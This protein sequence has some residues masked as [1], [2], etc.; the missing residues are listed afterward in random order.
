MNKDHEEYRADLLELLE[1]WEYM[2]SHEPADWEYEEL[3][4]ELK[5]L[6]ATDRWSVRMLREYLKEE[7]E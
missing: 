1:N 4:N 5:S 2:E 7:E 3:L 6:I